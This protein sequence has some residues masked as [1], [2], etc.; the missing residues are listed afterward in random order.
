MLANVARRVMNTPL[1]PSNGL[2]PLFEAMINS[3]DA[4]EDAGIDDGMVEIFIRRSDQ[5]HMF[6]ESGFR[7]ENTILGFDVV[8][9][10]LGFNDENFIS[11]N[12]SDSPLKAN[13]GGKGIGRFLWLKAFDHVEVDSVYSGGNVWKRRTFRFSLTKDGITELDVTEDANKQCRTEVRLTG[14]KEEYASRVPSALDRIA[15]RAIE[16]CLEYF[17]LDRAPAIIIHDAGNSL[18]LTTLYRE[19]ITSRQKTTFTLKK[20][21]FTVTHFMVQ[22]RAEVGHK[23]SYCANHRVVRQNTLT[24]SSVSNLPPRLP[25]EDANPVVYAGYVSGEYLDANVS[26]E[27][28]TFHIPVRSDSM[29]DDEVS[30][31][32]LEQAVHAEAGLF[33]QPF[34]EPVKS[35]K[36]ERVR[37]YVESKAPEYRPLLKSHVKRLDPIPPNLSD[38]KLDLALYEIQRDVEI[39][40]R[41]NGYKL[42]EQ[43]RTETRA[44][45]DETSL[46]HFLDQFVQFLEDWNE[47]GKANLA[48]YIVHR[49]AMLTFLDEALRL[50]RD[51]TY[52]LENAVH[53]I[54]FPLRQT[55]DDIAYEKHNLWILD[56]KLAYHYYA[57]SDLPLRKVEAVESESSDRPDLII[58]DKPIAAVLEDSAPFS[59]VVIFEFKRPM[60]NNFTD[61]KNPIA[62]VYG[63]VEQIRNGSVR[64]RHGRQFHVQSQTPFYCYIVCDLTP[65]LVAQ[66]KNHDL[67]KTPDDQGF[68]GYNSNHHAYIEV[69]AYDKLVRDAKRRNQ[70]LFDKLNMHGE[71]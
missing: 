21:D 26:Q 2:L 1:H 23:I 6:G 16:H 47:V 35:D 65:R 50:Q 9:N 11:F 58:F 53:E 44:E 24:A 30:W 56:E 66:A 57:A 41:R 67:K 29:L 51:G 62:Q 19:M 37:Q 70:I 18:N 69:I 13:R 71:I 10:G 7:S 8:D 36:F 60:I 52:A 61:D 17:V 33:L 20:H 54:I 32:E 22:A 38:S 49:K 14:F 27:R 63:Y 39:D 43:A 28:T 46:R 68:F 3:I 4:I 55:S 34:T 64:D 40:L 45:G 31:N 5:R 59:G 48:R 12:T 42:L 15:Q 25:A